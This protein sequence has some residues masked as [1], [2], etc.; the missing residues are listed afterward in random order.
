MNPDVVAA[1]DELVK[2][3]VLE[4]GAAVPLRRVASGSLVSVRGELRVLLWAGVLLVTTGVGPSRQAA[5]R[6]DRPRRHRGRDRRRRPRLPGLGLAAAPDHDASFAFDSV[7]LS[8]G[9]ARGR[10]SRVRRGQVHAAGAQL[11]LASRDRRRGLRGACVPVRLQGALL[12]VPDLV[13]RVARRIDR[14]RGDSLGRRLPTTIG[15]WSKR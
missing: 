10:R 9:V 2:T 13:R 3:G 8:G 7:L 12:A 11:A 5:S 14:R 15:F 6:P 1:I 4:R